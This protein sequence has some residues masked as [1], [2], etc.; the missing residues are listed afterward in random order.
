MREVAAARRAPIADVQAFMASL[1]DWANRLERDGVHPSAALYRAIA[2]DVLFP[3][4]RDAVAK[5]QCQR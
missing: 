5:L 3:V 1:P 4:V 2:A